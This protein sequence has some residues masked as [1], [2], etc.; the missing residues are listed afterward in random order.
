MTLINTASVRQQGASPR[1]ISLRVRIIHYGSDAEICVPTHS[2]PDLDVGPSYCC[3]TPGG[4]RSMATALQRQ[5]AMHLYRHSLKA[6]ISWA[7]RREIFY[8][9]V[10]S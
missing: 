7:V 4:A 5:R 3:W 2:A 9:E 10:S 1:N 8:E 6:I